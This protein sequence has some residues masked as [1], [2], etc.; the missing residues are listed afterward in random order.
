MEFRGKESLSNR[1]NQ[2]CFIA[3][4]EK[5]LSN[6]FKI[7]IKEESGVNVSVEIDRT[8]LCHSQIIMFII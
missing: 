2:S 3:V 7:K 1:V 8:L 6:E 4:S 5:S